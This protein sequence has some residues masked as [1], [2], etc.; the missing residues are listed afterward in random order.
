MDFAS[1][2]PTPVGQLMTNIGFLITISLWVLLMRV[3]IQNAINLNPQFVE[4]F[5]NQGKIGKMPDII[6]IGISFA[7]VLFSYT[8][9]ILRTSYH[10]IV[11]LVSNTNTTPFVKK[12]YAHKNDKL[13][14]TEHFIFDIIRFA[15]LILAPLLFKMYVVRTNDDN[16]FLI[17]YWF[18]GLC[19]QLSMLLLCILMIAIFIFHIIAIMLGD[20]E[21]I[22]IIL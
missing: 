4:I 19:I 5:S 16:T 2:K 22:K 20:K 14:D 1:E 12:I 9:N 6:Y 17:E 18:L 7:L 11:Q 13:C 8:S 21:Y 3:Y 10:S 15:T